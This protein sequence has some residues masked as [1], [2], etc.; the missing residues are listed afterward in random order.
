[1]RHTTP[2]TYRIEGGVEVPY[3]GLWG[4]PNMV[5]WWK[6]SAAERERVGAQTVLPSGEGIADQ[7]DQV[8]TADVATEEE[9]RDEL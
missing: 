2:G 7:T 4:V 6:T 1:M 9:T 5:A 8:P 3:D